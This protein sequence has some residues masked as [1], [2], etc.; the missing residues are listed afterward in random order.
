MWFNALLCNLELQVSAD[1][2]KPVDQ[3]FYPAA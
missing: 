3:A 2:G 1:I